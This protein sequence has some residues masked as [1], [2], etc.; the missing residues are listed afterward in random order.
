[1]VERLN[2]DTTHMTGPCVGCHHLQRIS[3]TDPQ[4]ATETPYE[5]TVPAGAV[6]L[7]HFDNW[8]R[9][10]A[11]KSGRTRYMLK[12]MYM[13]MEEPV[14]ADWDHR[15]ARWPTVAELPPLVNAQHYSAALAEALWDWMRGEWQVAVSQRETAHTSA[16][17]L[18]LVDN[19][20][21]VQVQTD[22]LQAAYS[23]RFATSETQGDAVRLAVTKLCE[24][25][26]EAF[27][28]DKHHEKEQ[29]LGFLNI[30]D[31][32]FA[33]ALSALGIV[34]APVLCALLA[35]AE[36]SESFLVRAVAACVIGGI[37][38]TLTT[39]EQGEQALQALLQALTDESEWVRRNA[40]H[41]VGVLGPMP[42]TALEASIATGLG[43]LLS[44]SADMVR[45][46]AAV[47]LARR[48]RE[49][50][51]LGSLEVQQ[52]REELMRVVRAPQAGIGSHGNFSD[53]RI[54]RYTR[55]YALDAL[56]RLLLADAGSNR[57]FLDY[58]M[59]QFWCPD[60]TTSSPF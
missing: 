41:A 60:T 6:A 21:S 43:S 36:R 32:P 16:M 19:D 15:N 2:S 55:F 52:I 42:S 44:D 38:S 5:F 9:G 7:A 24:S 18:A 56:R 29:A 20:E 22:R 49:V 48:A 25:G 23:L 1:M 31:R 11:N 47:S 3:H 30:A 26:A 4:I 10:G 13:R 40:A 14:R 39:S 12:W 51:L 50:V 53:P 37:G 59:Q 27:D 35:G 45:A 17:E 8:H 58:M 34:A 46:N 54:G 28:W 33:H 57:E